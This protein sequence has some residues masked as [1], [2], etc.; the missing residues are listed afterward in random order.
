MDQLQACA[1]FIRL[2][3]LSVVNSNPR[4][5][6]ELRRSLRLITAGVC[7]C[8]FFIPVTASPMLT[9]FLRN[10]GASPFHFGLL[11]GIPMCLFVLQFVAAFL[12]NRILNRKRAFIGLLV[13]ARLLYL[14][15]A[16]TPQLF[17]S[18]SQARQIHLIILLVSCSAALNNL[19]TP[20]WFAWMADLIPSRILGRYWG[21]RQR[22][23][24]VSWTVSYIAMAVFS[25]ATPWPINVTFPILA[26]IAVAAGLADICLFLRVPEPPNTLI[27]DV[28]PLQTLLEP[29]RH[30]EYRTFVRWSTIKAF[31][32][33]FAAT[34]LQLYALDGLEMPLWKV[35]IAWCSLGVGIA[36]SSRQWGRL[37][38]RHGQRPVLMLVMC[39]KPIVVLVFLLLTPA[40][41][42]PV[43][44]VW[45]FLDGILNGGLLV[46]SDG[47]MLR[48]APQANRSMFIASVAGLAGISG[49]LGAIAGGAVLGWLDGWQTEFLGREWNH[50]QVV[51]AISFIMRIL[52]IPLTAR[53]R[54]SK[55]TS[56]LHVLE[57]VAG[58]PQFLFL[59]F[60]IGLF[61]RIGKTA[62]T[63]KRGKS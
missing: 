41:A 26:V 63:P 21:T 57:D 34:F 48:M 22:W 24:F 16:F 62:S 20:M 15:I 29:F 30:A 4:D 8:M 19:A 14:A 7:L 52:C 38:D 61:R 45:F 28:K 49:G 25:Y 31:S 47:Y 12:N 11:V 13:S 60:P 6:N 33:M 9:E 58:T 50:F 1:S 35:T 23:L 3:T 43:L 42:F 18:V 59:R 37:T 54:E 17:S 36:L 53:I 27:R 46:A 2:P 51:F 56:P 55:S 32:V 10:I 5:T 40:T 44:T 39:G